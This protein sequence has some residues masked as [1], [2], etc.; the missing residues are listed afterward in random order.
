MDN[1]SQ[2]MILL[3]IL[4]IIIIFMFIGIIYN[5]SRILNALII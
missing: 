1:D 2:I 3:F 5:I 4:L